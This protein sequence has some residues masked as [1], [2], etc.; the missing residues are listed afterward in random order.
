VSGCLDDACFRCGA[1]N[2]TFA[3]N[4]RTH[5]DEA[6]RFGLKPEPDDWRGLCT[7]CYYAP[8]CSGPA[9]CRQASQNP[10]AVLRQPEPH[11]EEPPG[12]H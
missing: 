1:I 7:S 2:P 10:S 8:R 9:P 5:F 11:R 6:E 3:V 12:D 4:L